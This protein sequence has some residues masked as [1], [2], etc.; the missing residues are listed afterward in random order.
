M[1]RAIE[2]AGRGRYSCAPNPR[3]GCVV[4]KD[5]MLLAEGWHQVA[6]QGH[7]EVNALAQLAAG[8][9]VGATV[10]VSLEPCSHF[11]RTPPCADAL[12]SAGVAEVVVA[13]R[14]PNPQVAGSGI[15]A[16]TKAGIR[17]REA[18]LQEQ[19]E[20]LNRGYIRRM[21][22]GLPWL[23]CKLA[24][25]L[26]GRTAMASGESQWITGPSARVDVQ[27]LRAQSCAI[28][29]GIGTVLADDPALTA[30]AEGW[31]DPWRGDTL[32]Q[33]LRVIVDSQLRTPSQ[34]KLFHEGGQVIIACLEQ[35]ARK[36]PAALAELQAQGKLALLPCPDADGSGQRIDLAAL[37]KAL[38]ERQCNELMLEAG[39]A[40]AGAML[41][42]GLIDE[43]NVYLAPVIMGS[44][45]RPLFELPL[46]HMADRLQL[47]LCGSTQL[48]QDLRLDYLTRAQGERK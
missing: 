46:E 14:D 15:A 23:R 34:A 17:V 33:P 28:I 8:E 32:R 1:A 30:R 9:A 26:D 27:R 36:P 29:S 43:L 7:A 38:A 22:A 5:G 16:L 44:S 21:Q 35:A 25:S 40:L 42:A 24:M 13:M 4:I 11:G 20:A 37:L 48:G 2:L 41:R 39:A 3:V 31:Q 47:Q 12:I 19:A 45:G 6:G 10:Y 18:V